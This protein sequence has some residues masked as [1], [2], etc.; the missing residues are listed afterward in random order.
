MCDDGITPVSCITCNDVHGYNLSYCVQVKKNVSGLVPSMAM[1]LDDE[2]PVI[3]SGD[4]NDSEHSEI[5]SDEVCCLQ[6]HR[7]ILLLTN[8]VPGYI[9]GS[10]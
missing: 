6:H 10:E 5:D 2:Q 3:V 4:T 1:E 9:F 8:I 7:L